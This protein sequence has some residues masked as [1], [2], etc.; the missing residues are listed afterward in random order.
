MLSDKTQ[1]KKKTALINKSRYLTVW[2]WHFYAGLYV[3]PFMLMLCITGL[4]MLFDSEI[5]HAR[6]ASIID[7][8][9]EEHLLPVSEQLAAVHQAYPNYSVTQFIPSGEPNLANR[10]S[11][12]SSDGVSLFALVNPYTAQVQGTIDRSH[13]LYQWAN[14]IHATIL[15]GDSGDYLIEVAASLGILLLVS[16]L[17][18]WWPRTPAS[19]AGFLRV[20]F[21]QGRRTW[22]KDLHANIGGV[23]SL[24]LLFFLISGLSW[25]GFWG[26]QLV[27]A[28]N[29][30][31]TYYSWGAKPESV[32]THE[33]L[34]HGA[35][36]EMPWNL[37]QAPLPTSHDHSKMNHGAGFESSHSLSV[38][39]I[40]DKAHALG[41]ERYR[42]Y[43]P[44]SESGVYTLTANSM[45]GDVTDPRLERTAHFDQ[46]SG[47]LLIEV[48]WEDYSPFAKWMAASVSLHQGDLGVINKIAN[49]LICVAF[50]IFSIAAG[51]MWWIRR[52]QAQSRIGAPPKAENVA[53]WKVAL[54]TLVGLCIAFPLGG[55]T[56]V[57]VVSLDWMIVQRFDSFRRVFR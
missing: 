22:I 43:F 4:I 32:L 9:P 12:T 35:E 48:T 7:V 34:N 41:F 56:I 55:L 19:R 11:I 40:V 28:W 49:V 10:F 45:A 31:P 57:L 23:L 26:K 14:K 47:K 16:G 30:F 29:T 53:I 50:I 27:Q 2:R 17:Y 42:I 3:I 8:Q 52:P 51:A 21:R 1:L 18:L 44:Q 37:E 54:L 46:Y 39:Q 24:V 38:D 13:S 20:R 25:T 5:E 6:Y 36:K 33:N 15:L